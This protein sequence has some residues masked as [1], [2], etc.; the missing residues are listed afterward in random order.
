[1]TSGRRSAMRAGRTPTCCRTSGAAEHNERLADDFHGQGGPL[2]VADARSPSGFSELWLAAAEAQGMKRNA[3]F[4]GAEQEG[5]GFY[6]LTQR[7]GERWSA[8]RAYL[9]PNLARTNLA[10]RTRAH[11]ARVIFEDRRA[12]GIEL[13]AARCRAHRARAS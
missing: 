4:N 13:S 5:I 10:V 2:N 1:M 11:A 9:T 3:D 12:A 7:H 6:Q 8:A